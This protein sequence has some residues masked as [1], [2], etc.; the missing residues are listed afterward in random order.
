[1]Q[2]NVIEP[3]IWDSEFFGYPVANVSLDK[4]ESDELDCLFR[5]LESGKYRVTYFFVLP[6]E[7]ETIDHLVKKGGLL[8]DQKTTYSKVTEQHQQTTNNII[9][10]QGEEINDNLIQ[11][12]LE[13]GKYSRFRTDINFTGKEYE[14]LYIK[15]LDNSIKKINAFKTLLAIKGSEINGITTIGEKEYHAEIGLVAVSVNNRR[16]GIGQALINSAENIAFE[17]GFEKIKVVTQLTNEGACHLYE[18]CNFRI[19]NVTN[20]Y[21]YWQ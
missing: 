19:E 4:I 16:Q 7:K 11:L 8:V 12:V 5:K 9:E 15:W 13:S 10:F 18:K 14:R 17:M 21:H 20:I 1:M 2:N 6:D 3:L